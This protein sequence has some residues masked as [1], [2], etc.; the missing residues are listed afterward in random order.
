MRF[1]LPLLL[2]GC[3]LP[4]GAPPSEPDPRAGPT[5]LPGYSG[6]ACPGMHEG[7]NATWA[8]G[9]LLRSFELLLPE[10][11]AGAPLVF[12]WHWLG[13]SAGEL[14]STLDL[15]DYADRGAI[16]IAPQSTGL[17]V[18][19]DSLG[20]AADNVDLTLFDDLVTCAH[21]QF[22][23][24]L[25]RIHSLGMS[26]GGLWTSYLTMHRSDWHASTAPI[27]GGA[28]PNTYVTPDFDVPVLLTWGGPNDTH[29]AFSF[30]I[31]SVFFSQ[32][33]R[34][35]GHLVAECVH[36]GGH[37]IPPGA[38]DWIWAWFEGHRRGSQT[39]FAGGLNGD[40]PSWC[41]LNQ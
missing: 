35:D 32:E 24:D 33:L 5:E 2:V 22:G 39:P 37:L 18:E 6:E 8:S 3:T 29:G 17:E 28:E 13:S 16:V 4:T 26:A 40:F 23:F 30:D 7:T 27:S 36:S 20:D 38:P 12:A 11:P 31:A 34:D 9:S 1:L 41:R 25:D 14:V 19:W 15:Q 21:E 10:D